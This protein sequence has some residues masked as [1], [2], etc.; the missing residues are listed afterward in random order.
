MASPTSE[1]NPV[2]LDSH[3]QTTFSLP[4]TLLNTLSTDSMIIIV[5]LCEDVNPLVLAKTKIA[6][7]NWLCRLHLQLTVAKVLLEVILLQ[8]SGILHPLTLN[9]DN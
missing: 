3:H 7:R 1:I 9:V 4:A 6:M 8:K 5:M 2:G